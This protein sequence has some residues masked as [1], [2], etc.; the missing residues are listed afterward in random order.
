MIDVVFWFGYGEVDEG[1]RA[2]CCLLHPALVSRCIPTLENYYVNRVKR[3]TCDKEGETGFIGLGGRSMRE[4]CR[5]I[6][7]A[8]KTR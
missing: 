7:L 1:P 8:K 2:G 6:P 4:R 3:D 5:P